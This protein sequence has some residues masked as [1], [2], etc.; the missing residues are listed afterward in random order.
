MFV[1]HQ[2]CAKCMD[3]VWECSVVSD[4]CD[5]VDCRLP[6]S[7]VHGIFQARIL[8]WVAISFSRGSSQPRDWT[9]IS[10]TAGRF[11]TTEPPGKPGPLY[12]A[13]ILSLLHLL[14]LWL[15]MSQ[16]SLVERI[17]LDLV[18]SGCKGGRRRLPS[19]LDLQCYWALAQPRAKV[20]LWVWP[21][22]VSVSWASSPLTGAR[23]IKLYL[24]PS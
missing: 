22:W 23:E 8:K 7:S 21:T 17:W 14:W 13:I 9:H 5:P 4:S 19:G 20:I 6:G 1:E 18:V 15:G 24:Y 3:L 16:I 11:F 12:Q 2:Q 10:H